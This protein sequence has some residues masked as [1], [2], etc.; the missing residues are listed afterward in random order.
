MTQQAPPNPPG[1]T[2]DDL[3]EWLTPAP[4]G[5]EGVDPDLERL[6]P[7]VQWFRPLFMVLIMSFAGLVASNFREDLEY[8]FSPSEPIELGEATDYIE[9]GDAKLPDVPHNRLVK[10]SG[11][12]DPDRTGISCAYRPPSRFY[13]LIGAPFYV[14]SALPEDL[15]RLSCK[16]EELRVDPKTVNVPFYEG[17]G[18]AVVLSKTEG[19]T[20]TG[21]R[22][23]YARVTGVPFCVDLTPALKE[24]RL[25]F[26]RQVL[27]ERA[28]EA[29]GAYPSD[30]ELER[31]VAQEPLCQDAILIEGDLKPKDRW[32]SLALVGALGIVMLWNLVALVRWTRGV[33]RQQRP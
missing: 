33:M 4:Q 28:K 2:E 29:T 13:K 32:P 24:S 26:F 5:A 19:K 1:I 12:P 20:H 23:F 15:T 16:A 7:P 14:Q 30:A 11:I 31:Q 17:V 8:F 6:R 27:R 25:Q 22:S 3:D 9:G 10:L 21:L 18:R